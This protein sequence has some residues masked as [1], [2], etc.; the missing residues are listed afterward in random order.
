MRKREWKGGGDGI[1]GSGE[2]NIEGR[3]RER[4]RGKGR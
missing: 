2:R 1:E 3:E 4:E